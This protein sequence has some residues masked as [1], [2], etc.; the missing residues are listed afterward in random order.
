MHTREEWVDK[1]SLE[2][3]L[4]LIM[5]LMLGRVC[6]GEGEAARDGESAA[7]AVPAAAPVVAE[8]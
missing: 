5:G 1:D 2:R 6:D 7:V 3:G 4:A 8:E